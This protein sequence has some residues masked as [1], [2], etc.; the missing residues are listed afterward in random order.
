MLVRA[1]PLFLEGRRPC[2]GGR[3]HSQI[4]GAK[5]A[6]E[7]AIYAPEVADFLAQI[8]WLTVRDIRADPAQG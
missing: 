6:K 1:G 4:V 8:T 7:S 2:P 3:V 5:M